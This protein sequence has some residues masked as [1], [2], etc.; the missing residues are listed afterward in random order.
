M[1]DNTNNEGGAATAESGWVRTLGGKLAIVGATS[2][3]LG[4]TALGLSGIAAADEPVLDAGR[5]GIDRI[6]DTARSTVDVDVGVE[7]DGAEAA[8]DVDLSPDDEDVLEA[9]ERC[10][11]EAGFDDGSEAGGSEADGSV[12]VEL[13]DDTLELL[14][15][16]LESCEPILE[17]LEGDL[18]EG[19]ELSPEDEAL[20]E[21]FDECL[22]DAGI[23]ELEA[24][25]EDGEISDD[26]LASLEEAFAE[27]E[28]ILDDLEGEAFAF[29]GDVECDELDDLHEPDEN[30]DEHDDQHDEEAGS[31]DDA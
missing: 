7:H 4:A 29:L 11:A 6:V 19:S 23:D 18:L 15:D 17:D 5:A 22:V 30:D 21:E 16:A 28:A 20:F 8:V 9:F 12:I 10:L 13:D 25:Y 1:E 14:D 31:D 27:C 24:G 26:E 2:V 3:V